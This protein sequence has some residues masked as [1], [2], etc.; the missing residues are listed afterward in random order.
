ML[1]S[2]CT[3]FFY[4]V[5]FFSFTTTQSHNRYG[6]SSTVNLTTAVFPTR[7]DEPGLARYPL[8]E[9]LTRRTRRVLS[10]TDTIEE[11]SDVDVNA[12]DPAASR[13]PQPSSVHKARRPPLLRL[14]RRTR[15][16]FRSKKSR[17]ST[18]HKNLIPLKKLKKSVK[19]CTT[20]TESPLLNLK[21]YRSIEYSKV[22]L[23]S[24]ATLWK[25]KFLRHTK[26][27]PC[28]LSSSTPSIYFP[29]CP[30]DAESTV[31]ISEIYSILPFPS[32]L[33]LSAFPFYCSTP[34]NAI[35]PSDEFLV[36][37]K[38]L[39]DTQNKPYDP[40]TE[41][42][43]NIEFFETNYAE[44]IQRATV[45]LQPAIVDK[46][47]LFSLIYTPASGELFLQYR[48]LQT[49]SFG[50]G[51]SLPETSL[52][53]DMSMTLVEYVNVKRS[54]LKRVRRRQY[55]ETDNQSNDI[56]YI[57]GQCPKC[58]SS[59]TLAGAVH[60][61]RQLLL[62]SI[63]W[64]T[65]HDLSLANFY[66]AKLRAQKEKLFLRW[67]AHMTFYADPPV[68]SFQHRSLRISAVY[69]ARDYESLEAHTV[70]PTLQTQRLKWIGIPPLYS[71][72]K[73]SPR[74]IFASPPLLRIDTRIAYFTQSAS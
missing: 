6:A 37:K 22:M 60:L 4:I 47:V 46:K 67:A 34:A 11:S 72:L 65:E 44:M 54:V 15:K 7:N 41:V 19:L 51:T 62:A 17:T 40:K 28:S 66:G 68:R 16:P 57:R 9:S 53:L 5:S 2:T 14:F 32:R 10:E 56:K 38:K 42:R 71:I 52:V 61:S 25:S 1:L 35:L 33:E 27:A 63:S 48:D 39:L 26:E 3:L 55:A 18:P 30:G 29:V 73:A 59:E 8:D 20:S 23:M 13:S 69:F 24:G 36:E 31:L 50:A 70:G 45:E 58:K 43:L 12:D 21:G 74:I 64:G 49:S